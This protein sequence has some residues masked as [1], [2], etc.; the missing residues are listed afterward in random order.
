M[1]TKTIRQLKKGEAFMRKESASKIYTRG[2]YVRG[3]LGLWP[4]GYTCN[5]W[6]DI[7]RSILLNGE[8]V[9]FTGFDY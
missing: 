4:T 5:D 7:S 8:T 3:K 9:V 6:T 2:E 1:E